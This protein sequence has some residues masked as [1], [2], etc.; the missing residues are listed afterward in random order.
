VTDP[1]KIADVYADDR[2]GDALPLAW[3]QQ[4][5]GAREFYTAHILNGILWAMGD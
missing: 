1:A 5:D 4:F 2:F 3:I